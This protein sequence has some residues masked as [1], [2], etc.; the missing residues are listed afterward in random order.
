MPEIT[1][2]KQPKLR[3]KSR[4]GK[5]QQTDRASSVERP[6]RP[7]SSLGK[8]A[9]LAWADRTWGEVRDW[10]DVNVVEM[11]DGIKLE[12]PSSGG[13]MRDQ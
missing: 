8:K 10:L 9:A 4:R 11:P 2:G 12:K 7:T 6:G 13:A 3:R 1:L 5:R